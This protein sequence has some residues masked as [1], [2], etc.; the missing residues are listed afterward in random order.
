MKSLY[1]LKQAQKQW[2][3]KFDYAMMAN[4]FNECDKCVY[5]KDTEYGYFMYLYVD[6]MFIVDSNDR[7]SNLLKICWIQN[8]T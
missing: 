1:D 5:I 2:H 4:G 3:E 6:D 7:W 8:L